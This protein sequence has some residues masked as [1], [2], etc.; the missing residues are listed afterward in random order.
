MITHIVFFKLADAKQES[1]NL[2]CEKLLSMRGRI[3]QLRHLEAGADVIR[4]ERSYD[5]ALITRFDSLDELQAYQVHPYHAGEVV[6]LMKSLCSSIV[7]V[8]FE[9]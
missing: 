2:V 9:S 7:A 8:D 5:V 3:P 1:M 4:S 6:P